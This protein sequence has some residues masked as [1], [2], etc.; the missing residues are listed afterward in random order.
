[1][2]ALVRKPSV[3]TIAGA[4]FVKK[5]IIKKRGSPIASALFLP[6]TGAFSPNREGSEKMG[7]FVLL[8]ISLTGFTA[9]IVFA[10]YL[11]SVPAMLTL[12]KGS[13]E[14]I[15]KGLTL[16]KAGERLS[17]SGKTGW[18]L[19]EEARVLVG[20]RMAYCR[21]NSYDS[22]A[23]AFLRGYGYCTQSAYALS[24]LLRKIGITAYPVY[25]LSCK[26]DDGTGGHTWVRV[27]HNGE[28]HDIDPIWYDSEIRAVQFHPLGKVR[29]MTPFFFAFSTWGSAGVNAWRYYRTGKDRD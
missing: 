16:T 14:G 23:G 25:S 22:P 21:R 13:R 1:M 28:E 18:E 3:K 27:D 29:K 8:L 2:I 7:L 19:V 20:D 6:K 17:A 4:V 11:I 24:E 15:E 5:S 12:S 10:W 9:F 26:F